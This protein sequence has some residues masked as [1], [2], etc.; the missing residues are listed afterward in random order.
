MSNNTEKSLRRIGLEIAFLVLLFIVFQ[1]LV[2]VKERDGENIQKKILVESVEQKR[3]VSEQSITEEPTKKEA[4]RLK[5]VFY[6]TVGVKTKIYDRVDDKYLERMCQDA[7]E[8]LREIEASQ[9]Q[10][11]VYVDRNPQKQLGF[12]C[13]FDSKNKQIIVIGKD[14]VSTGNPKRGKD[15]F[16]TPVGVFQNTL[17]NFGYRALGTKN[18]KG[19]R[20]LGRKGARV[21]DFGW[22]ETSKT[23]KAKDKIL[24]RLL[25]HATDPDFG[26]PRLGRV[27]SKGCV[28]ISAQLNDFLDKFGILDKEYEDHYHKGVQWLLRKDRQAVC[29]AG[30][31]L[32]IGDS[33][34][35]SS[36]AKK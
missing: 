28:R 31:Y 14:L 7:L 22:Q 9:D 30:K 17:D 25:M 21:W 24:I 34:N 10:Y 6:Q 18:K 32:I 5:T 26:E 27:D 36:N 12:V 2:V 35:I 1:I 11:F 3:Q 8:R 4:A 13:F 23:I 15:Y 19:W 16:L 20:G 33:G 29:C